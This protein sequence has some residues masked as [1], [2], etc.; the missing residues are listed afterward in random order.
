MQDRECVAL[1]QW[2]L[3][4]L[5]R[6]WAGF[7]KVR[8]Q[9]CRR[10]ECRRRA[11]ALP[12]IAA[13][14][15]YLETHP[16]EWQALDD[17]CAITISCFYRDTAMWEALTAAVLPQLAR[18]ALARGAH[19]LQAASLGCA[20]GEEPY[21]LALAWQFAV[22]AQFPRLTLAVTATDVVEAL[23]QRAR[24]ACYAATSLKLLP[25]AWRTHGFEGAGERFCLRARFRAG[26]TFL[27]QDLRT[28]LPEGPFDL[29]LCRNLAFTYFDTPSQQAM[30]AR[31]LAHLQPGGALVI[32]RREVLPAVAGGVASWPDAEQQAIFRYT[33]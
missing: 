20:S 4:R 13:Y 6:P 28:A 29:I 22:A 25:P 7:R 1:L 15:N 3:P 11:L 16:H 2:A 14:R 17:L 10:I 24:V 9:V 26:V 21:T 5:R 31:L 12:D 18:Q 30:L 23:L 32:G 27:R 19:A 33:P 8:N